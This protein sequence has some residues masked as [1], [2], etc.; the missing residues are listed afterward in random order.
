[1]AVVG[2]QF[3]LEQ[4]AERVGQVGLSKFGTANKLGQVHL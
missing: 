4:V 1:M 2:Q 3:S